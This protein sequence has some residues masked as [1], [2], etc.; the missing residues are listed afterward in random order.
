M[1]N[2][3]IAKIGKRMV[4]LINV[5]NISRA[6]GAT[7]SNPLQRELGGMLQLLKAAD[8]PYELELS[9]EAQDFMQIETLIV[10]GQEFKC[11]PCLD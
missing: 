1:N 10:N 3:T 2:E 6:K 7:S 8:V 11:R 9:D 5:V 4:A